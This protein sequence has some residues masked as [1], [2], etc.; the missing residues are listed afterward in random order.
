MVRLSGRRLLCRVYL[1]D[2][3]FTL[4]W[5]LPEDVAAEVQVSVSSAGKVEI[6]LHKSSAAQWA[7]TGRVLAGHRSST[8][9]TDFSPEFSAFV[10]VERRQVTHDT[11]LLLLRA[12]AGCSARL[13]LGFHVYIRRT[14]CGAELVRP[15]TP[16]PESIEPTAVT[17]GG[18]ALSD[19]QGLPGR[20][21]DTA[22]GRHAAS[23]QTLDVSE[24]VGSF[25]RRPED[26]SELVMLAAG[27][28]LT[29]DGPSDTGSAGRLR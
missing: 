4:H 21:A 16:V 14:V 11:R 17:G 29:P 8:P 25:R 18:P 9:L 7:S 26:V 3:V 24:P 22:A 12:P 15:Y 6:V 1:R 20:R 13:P 27:T 28:G 2:S 10:L 5:E 19:G 23:G